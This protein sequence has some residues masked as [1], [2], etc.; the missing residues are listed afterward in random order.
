MHVYSAS[1]TLKT[2]SVMII[3][4][5]IAV[6]LVNHSICTG[7]KASHIKFQ[8]GTMLVAAVAVNQAVGCLLY[9]FY[10]KYSFVEF[11]F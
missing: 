11:L 1:K 5:I 4:V 3:K 8:Q 6:I 9:F 2:T 7:Y 10:L